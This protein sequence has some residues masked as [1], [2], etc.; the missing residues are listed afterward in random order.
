MKYM[1]IFIIIIVVP[2]KLGPFLVYAMTL[3]IFPLL[4][5]PL[6]LTSYNCV[7]DSQ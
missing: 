7:K 3:A 1:L 5:T 6:K 2:L 4:E